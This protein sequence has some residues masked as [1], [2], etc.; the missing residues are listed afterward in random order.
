MINVSDTAAVRTRPPHAF[1][2]GT[3][4]ALCN[5]PDALWLRVGGG[6]VCLR[7]GTRPGTGFLGYCKFTDF[8]TMRTEAGYAVNTSTV[9]TFQ[10]DSQN[11]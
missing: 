9:V 4:F 3:L 6:A 11:T 5:H 1:P 8:E 10:N 7:Q 2:A